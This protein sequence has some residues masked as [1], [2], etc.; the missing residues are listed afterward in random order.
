MNMIHFA[1]GFK[2][3]LCK[4][5]ISR[6]ELES[7]VNF[8]ERGKRLGSLVLMD[9]CG[10]SSCTKRKNHLATQPKEKL[11]ELMIELCKKW[12]GQFR[13]TAHDF[14]CRGKLKLFGIF[15]EL[16]DHDFFHL[17]LDYSLD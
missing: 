9:Y 15:E 8:H 11:D 14:D 16:L 7:S 2:G 5:R 17:S 1:I 12:D 3:K 13:N 10:K 6:I 4:E